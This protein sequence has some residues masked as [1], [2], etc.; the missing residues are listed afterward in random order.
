MGIETI[1]AIRNLNNKTPTKIDQLLTTF[2]MSGTQRSM[3]KTKLMSL[4]AR[5]VALTP[6]DGNPPP[7]KYWR[8]EA[9]PYKARYPETWW[10]E[11]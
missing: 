6:L 7:A 1:G 11:I 2:P 5:C 4:I 3:G 9:H 10:D 8:K